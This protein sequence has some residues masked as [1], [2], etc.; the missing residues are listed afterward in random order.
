MC[1]LPALRLLLPVLLLV[2]AF[3]VPGGAA[4]AAYESLQLQLEQ[5]NQRIDR[6]EAD[7]KTLQSQ[8]LE[9]QQGR[10]PARA[11]QHNLHDPLIGVWQ[12]TNQV[13]TYDMTFFAD[14]L[15]LQESTTLGPMRELSWT[16]VGTDEILLTGGVKLRTSLSAADQM[17]AENLASRAK[18]ACRKLSLER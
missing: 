14:G 1:K 5:Q 15:L 8:L 3:A 9:A 12:C 2:F 10:L 18:W 11:V 7:V 13:F 6:L 4:T 16:R 17:I